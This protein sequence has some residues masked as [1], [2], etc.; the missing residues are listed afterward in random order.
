M[1][2]QELTGGAQAL[3]SCAVSD[4]QEDLPKPL[5]PPVTCELSLKSKAFHIRGGDALVF[6][7]DSDVRWKLSVKNDEKKITSRFQKVWDQK[8]KTKIREGKKLTSDEA[9]DRVVPC[10][11]EDK[12]T[13]VV[14]FFKPSFLY[15]EF[16]VEGVMFVARLRKD[17]RACDQ[18]WPLSKHRDWSRLSVHF[19]TIPDL[20][21]FKALASA[22]QRGPD[23]LAAE[24][25]CAYTARNQK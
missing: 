2:D 12:Q 14:G 13:D 17:G 15:R 8:L 16:V 22:Q 25:L 5:P 11:P 21:A 24:I 4:A 1:Q 9:R 10:F 3:T 19:P 18:F 6:G 23:E 7:D 20:Q